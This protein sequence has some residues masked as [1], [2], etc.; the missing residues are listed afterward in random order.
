LVH[1]G[2]VDTD[3]KVITGDTF[4]PLILSIML[5]KLHSRAFIQGCLLKQE[6]EGIEDLPGT[7]Q[8]RIAVLDQHIDFVN[9]QLKQLVSVKSIAEDK[10]SFYTRMLQ[11]N[12]ER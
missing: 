4:Y 3:I 8:N 9:Q 12:V 10:S 7:L 1:F 2:N 11:E 6:D 5:F